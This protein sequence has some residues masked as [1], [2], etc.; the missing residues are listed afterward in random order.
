MKSVPR[1]TGK[2]THTCASNEER[3]EDRIFGGFCYPKCEI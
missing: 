2:P 3:I 1:G